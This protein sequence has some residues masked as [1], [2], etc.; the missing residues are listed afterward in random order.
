M[1]KRFYSIVERGES[2]YVKA[3]IPL[4]SS[5]P[6]YSGVRFWLT[7]LFDMGGGGSKT[8]T[9]HLY[10]LIHPSLRTGSGRAFLFVFFVFEV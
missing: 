9:F 10:I 5:I 3:L 7:N 4:V 6:N 1:A 8:A 2:G